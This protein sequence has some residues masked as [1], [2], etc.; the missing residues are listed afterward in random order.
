MIEYGCLARFFNDYKD[1]V[2]FA[3]ENDFSIMQ[4][5]Y[6][7][8]GL[9][10][11]KDSKPLEVIKECN[12]NTII[13]AVLD[14]NEIEEHITKL[15][16]MLKYLGHRELIIHPV[17]KSEKITN[18]TIYKLSDRIKKASI[19]LHKENI[20]LYLEN[21]SKLDPIFNKTEEINILFN[22]N[23]DVEFLLDL[24][25]ID[26]YQHLN[27]MVKIKMPK[28]LHI[29]DRHLEVVHEHL[30]IGDGNIDFNHIFRTALSKFDGKIIFEIVQSPEDIV[31]SRDIIKQMLECV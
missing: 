27:D 23:K 22:E 5:W 17:C 3:K 9:A 15:I 13:H 25:H 21:N 28:I 16:R 12:F 2:T 31:N 7:S 26:D 30:P 24:A 10:L 18:E 29:A 14:I 11:N 1:E 6:D 4:L 8:N 19:L 20:K